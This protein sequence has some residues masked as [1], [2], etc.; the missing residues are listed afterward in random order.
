MKGKI[1]IGKLLFCIGRNLPVAHHRCRPIGIISKKYRQLCGQL[2]LEKCGKN[3]NIYPKSYFDTELELGD[4]SD[5]GLKANLQGKVIIG[6]DVIMGPE[7]NIWTVNHAYDRMDI[8]IKYQGVTKAQPVI[9]GSGVWIGSRV[10][11]LPGVVIG[12]GAIVGSG[13]VVTKSVPD[14]AIVGGNPAK[15]IKYRKNTANTD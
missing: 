7:C 13:A 10:T 6:N 5:I 14:Y 9:I 1:I 11:I 15:I 2:L 8:P 12:E 4:N 3:V